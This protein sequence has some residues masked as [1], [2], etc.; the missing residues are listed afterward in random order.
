MVVLTWPVFAGLLTRTLNSYIEK[1]NLV[2]KAQVN[3]TSD[4]AREGITAVISVKVPDPKFSLSDQ[5]QIG[6]W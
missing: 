2:K 1:E 4:D 3:T 6:V 5:G